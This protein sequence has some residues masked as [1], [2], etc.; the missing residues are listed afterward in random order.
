MT[1]AGASKSLF[2]MGL[3]NDPGVIMG[4]K[5]SV[6]IIIKEVSRYTNEGLVLKKSLA[7][8]TGHVNSKETGSKRVDKKKK[9]IQGGRAKW[10]GE[11]ERERPVLR[12]IK[13]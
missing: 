4:K 11:K 9:R 1:K 13:K 5:D 12:M 3:Y 7:C 10:G 2:V 6:I 8:D